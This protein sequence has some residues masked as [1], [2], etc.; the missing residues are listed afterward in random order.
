MIEIS[1]KRRRC[2]GRMPQTLL[3]LFFDTRG[4]TSDMLDAEVC[5]Q[6]SLHGESKAA[7]SYC[8]SFPIEIGL[9]A[10]EVETRERF[11]SASRS[12]G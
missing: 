5:Y 4:T 7:S 1:E 10:L 9:R 8:C 3:D 11:C 6:V 12:S 2:D